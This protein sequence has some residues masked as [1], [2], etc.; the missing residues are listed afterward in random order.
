MIE[1]QVVNKCRFHPGFRFGYKVNS[2][3][4]IV[5]LGSRGKQEISL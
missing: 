2:A 4:D 1:V 5:N 3:P